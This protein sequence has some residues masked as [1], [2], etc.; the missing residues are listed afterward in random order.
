MSAQRPRILNLDTKKALKLRRSPCSS[1]DGK[2][3]GGE[4]ED[5]DE[6]EDDDGSGKIQAAAG[7]EATDTT[8]PEVD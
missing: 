2:N 1:D 5:D 8:A 4:E 7:E 3:Q 6:D